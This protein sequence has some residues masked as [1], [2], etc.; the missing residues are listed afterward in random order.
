MINDL[1]IVESKMEII[2]SY[3]K[4]LATFY[5]KIHIPIGELFYDIQNQFCKT[6]QQ[7]I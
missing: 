2:R 4:F 7:F 5:K 3:N 6:F 1:N